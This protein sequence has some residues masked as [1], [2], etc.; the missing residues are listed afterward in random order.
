[1]RGRNQHE[2]HMPSS[3]LFRSKKSQAVRLPKAAAFPASVRF[4][5]IVKIGRARLVTPKGLRWDDLFEGGPK[6]SEDFF[7][8]Q[9]QPEIEKREQL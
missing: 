3:R 7:A 1:M 8:G 2:E 5:D 4:V 9:Q 6:V